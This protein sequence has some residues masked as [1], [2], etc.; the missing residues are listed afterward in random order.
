MDGGWGKSK[1]NFVALGLV[2]A[3]V[4]G[5]VGWKTINVLAEDAVPA[6]AA[7][8]SLSDAT[9]EEINRLN[10]AVAQ[11]KQNIENLQ[12]RIS[13]VKAKIDAR[14]GQ[15]ATLENQ[16]AILENRLSKTELDLQQTQQEID[17]ATLE[18]TALDLRITEESTVIAK[19]K[20]YLQ[21]F[22]R[23][24]SRLSDKSALEVLL[25]QDSFSEFYDQLKRMQDV[26]DELDHTLRDVVTAREYLQH[27]Q[28]DKEAQKAKL[29]ELR[30][31]LENTNSELGEEKNAKS[32]LSTSVQQ[33]AVGLSQDLATLRSQQ[34][35][36]D[37]DLLT[38]ER[39]LRKKLEDAKK[40]RQKTETE[41][42]S[43]SLEWPVS[44]ARGITTYF[45]DPDYPFRYIFEHPGLDIRA[46]QG[47]PIKA[48]ASGFVGRA[49][50]AGMGYSYIMVIHDDG[51]ST[52]YGHVSRILVKENDFV[53][54]GDVIG[55]TGATPGTPGAGPLTTGPHLHFEV[56]LNGIPVNPLEY[57]PN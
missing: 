29:D 1:L 21:D 11:K 39:T 6:P 7:E 20:A 34:Q 38:L 55:L 9:Q 50:D 14:R 56:R 32:D 10:D 17:K 19:K 49:K 42:G 47:T 51:L 15:A 57:L 28:V 25:S 48:A 35:S 53:E 16:L 4:F 12:Q 3:A 43:T 27:Q 5:L 41:E 22:V 44:P 26:S 2:L 33:E 24:I 36:V 13:S 30:Q 40:L 52:V 54:Q 8:P 46:S 45:H 37:N 23:T 31:K 18:I